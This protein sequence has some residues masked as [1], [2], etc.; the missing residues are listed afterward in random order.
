MA[1]QEPF[2]L[3]TIPERL[4]CAR[5]ENIARDAYKLS[6]CDD[7]LCGNCFNGLTATIA[8]PLCDHT[9]FEKN[10][11][12]P[13]KS[14]RNTV[15]V[16][17][18][19][20]EKRHKDGLASQTTTA[21]DAN[22]QQASHNT[23]SLDTTTTIHAQAPTKG[24]NFPMDT[25][26]M[27]QMM[28]AGMM[29]MALGMGM[30]MGMGMPMVPTPIAGQT[31]PDG[32]ASSMAIPS[33]G[34]VSASDA[35][36]REQFDDRNSVV[37]GDTRAVDGDGGRELS[38]GKTLPSTLPL[39][40]LP[41][42]T[43]AAVTD[44]LVSADDR[45][46][47]DAKAAMSLN[48]PKGPASMR[49]RERA[50]ADDSLPYRNRS[51][52]HSASES[53]SRSRSRPRADADD[54]SRRQS[55]AATADHSL[56]DTHTSD[57]D[58]HDG[59]RDT[60]DAR[61]RRL[62]SPSQRRGRK[63]SRSPALSTISSVY[64]TGKVPAVGAGLLTD[65]HRRYSDSRHRG[66]EAYTHRDDPANIPVRDRSRSPGP[67][68]DRRTER[69][70][71]DRPRR[72]D[73]D[74]SRDSKRRRRSRDRR[75]ARKGEYRSRSYSR[76]RSRSRSPSRSRRRSRRHESRSRSPRRS[77]VPSRRHRRHRSRS[78]TPPRKPTSGRE[79]LDLPT[80]PASSRVQPP[81]QPP[82]QSQ[83][84]R[85][86]GGS[87]GRSFAERLGLPTST[88][89]AKEKHEKQPR[90]RRGRSRTRSR[91]RSRSPDGKWSRSRSPPPHNP[92]RQNSHT[93]T[94]KEQQH[95]RTGA[96]SPSRKRTKHRRRGRDRDRKRTRDDADHPEQAVSVAVDKHADAGFDRFRSRSRSR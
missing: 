92:H 95:E 26:M 55:F 83:P 89:A 1:P 80:G 11:A 46:H 33:E 31:L 49:R 64:N 75:R 66:R 78:R 86:A 84:Q 32:A 50:T 77:P 67:A 54:Y 34:G 28:M 41:A 94:S 96:S 65:R 81:K 44:A 69:D 48:L 51:H 25:I 45:D 42:A 39:Q 13:N 85:A 68:A 87:G 91:S 76:S 60:R 30:G 59:D 20:A 4:K 88:S 19:H 15:T 7:N 5:C 16:F 2:P 3:G 40:E 58:N 43:A 62:P 47:G 38:V 74:R 18:K 71:D 61:R 72:A 90:R 70:R 8:C 24:M 56:S 29:P 10:A 9:P 53:F 12:L 17:L 93:M 36:S 23:P 14:L 63:R 52:D 22:G 35:T 21:A 82:S 6:C 27:Q 73:R 79:G 37:S 57:G